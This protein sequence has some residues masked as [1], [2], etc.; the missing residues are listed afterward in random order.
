[1]N[2][3]K[4]QKGELTIGA[5]LF[6]AV[7]VVG[8]YVGIKMAIPKVRNYQ[9]KEVFRN[10]IGRLK[11]DP[12]MVVRANVLNKIKE[13]GVSFDPH[14]E[15]EDGLLIIREEGELPVMKATF[16]MEVKFITGHKYTY[17]FHP[18]KVAKQK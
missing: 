11:V 14:Y 4:E 3:I 18:M 7:V 13:L 10:E 8:G 5:I 1:M 17:V 9:V 15:S 16:R 2:Y 12:E 6:I